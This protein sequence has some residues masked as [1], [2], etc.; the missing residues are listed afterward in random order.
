M[1]LTE[2]IDT[3]NQQLISLFGIDTITGLAMWRVVWS[4]DQMEKRLME[5]TDS[6]ITLLTPEYREVPK[7]RQWIT[8]KYVLENLVVVPEQ[9]KKELGSKLSYEPIF[10]FQDG[11]DNY[12]PPKLEVAKLVI[13]TIYAAQGK[14]SLAKY[15]DPDIDPEL[16]KKKVDAIYEELYGN[17]T[18][19]NTSMAHGEAIVVPHKQKES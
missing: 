4:E 12:L 5:H 18:S 7:Y 9:H 10:V 15:K 19:I 14:T 2:K 17:E 6:G 1:E 8:Q 3:I 16:H 11:R 13:D